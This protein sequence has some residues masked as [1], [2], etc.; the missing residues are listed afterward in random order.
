[1]N[2]IINVKSV[3]QVRDALFATKQVVWDAYQDTS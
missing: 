3:L 1:M 2:K